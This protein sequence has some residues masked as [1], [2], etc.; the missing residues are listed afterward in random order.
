[1]KD[2][3]EHRDKLEMDLKRDSAKTME[4]TKKIEDQSLE[5]ER[6]KNFT[7]DHNK[8]CYE[9]KKSKDQHQA[10]RKLVRLLIKCF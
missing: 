4:L 6:Q 8:Q 5:S 3:K 9:L 7:D 1:M 10:T 2:K